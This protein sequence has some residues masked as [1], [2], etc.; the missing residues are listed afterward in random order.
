MAGAYDFDKT[1]LTAYN[2]GA[3]RGAEMVNMAEK[4]NQFAA[5]QRLREDSFKLQKGA[6]ERDIQAQEDFAKHSKDY[7]DSLRREEEYQRGVEER[8]TYNRGLHPFNLDWWTSE[9]WLSDFGIGPTPEESY[10]RQMIREGTPELGERPEAYYPEIS[11]EMAGS[12]RLM[13]TMRRERFVPQRDKTM[14]DLM[15]QIDIY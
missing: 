1:I 5:L 14:A 3:N 9:R 12:F 15:N 11:P 4:R 7:S 13:E 8:S 6:Y 2:Q 10:R